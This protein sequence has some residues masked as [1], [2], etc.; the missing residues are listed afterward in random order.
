LV[1]L[2]VVRG[3]DDAHP[4]DAEHSLYAVLA[5]NNVTFAYSRRRARLA[6]HHAPALRPLTTA[7]RANLL[8]FITKIPWLP[9][10]T[11]GL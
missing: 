5:G 4:A 6:L 1:E 3:T 8:N 2:E 11:S 10:Y 9:R 7:I